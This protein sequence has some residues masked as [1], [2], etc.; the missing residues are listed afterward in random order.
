MNFLIEIKQE[1]EKASKKFP[2]FHSTHEGY[3]VIKEELDELWDNI[4]NNTSK[5]LLKEEAIQVGAM[6]LRFLIDCCEEKPIK[7]N[8][9]ENADL[10]PEHDIC[11]GCGKPYRKEK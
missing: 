5:E 7:C 8:C 4:K 1:Y 11:I 2:N 9:K 3:A 10:V 6:A